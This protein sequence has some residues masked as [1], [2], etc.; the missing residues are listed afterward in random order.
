MSAM[1][2]RRQSRAAFW[3]QRIAVFLIPFFLVVIAGQR[4][5]FIDTPSVLTLLGLG[6][7]L[8]LLSLGL[9]AIGLRQLW[10]YGDKG[11]MQSVRGIV[12]SL[13]MFAPFGWFGWLAFTLPPIH[14]ITTDKFEPPQFKA[15][16]KLRTK[17]MNEIEPLT[18]ELL[19]IQ[20]T[21]YPL[22]TSRRYSTT[23]DRVFTA[24]ITLIRARGWQVV[25]RV[26]TEVSLESFPI[27]KEGSAP[28]HPKKP[29]ITIPAKRPAPP[30]EL[31][32]GELLIGDENAEVELG[33]TYVEAV[34]RSTVMGFPDDVI[35]RIIEEEDGALVDM[36]SASRWGIHDMGANARRITAF[37]RDLDAALAGVAG[38]G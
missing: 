28:K 27:D 33:V 34:A 30:K 13:M 19:N 18:S 16:L 6:L 9:G 2:K 26:G 12:L 7:I 37:L 5:G 38:E 23:S 22:V 15:A 29:K 31:A 35:V 20:E 8:I 24:V 1:L 25:G 3:C 11:G 4:W 32:E 10:L 21:F 17:G 36:R 14:D